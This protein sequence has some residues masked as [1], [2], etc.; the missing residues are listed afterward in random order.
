MNE[1]ITYVRDD[2]FNMSP[3][4]HK[5]IAYVNTPWN[6]EINICAQ[7]FF[8][9]MMGGIKKNFKNTWTP[10]STIIHE[11]AHCVTGQ[12]DEGLRIDGIGD[13]ITVDIK[14][15]PWEAKSGTK[16]YGLRKVT[17]L[18]DLNPEQTLNVADCYGVF[19]DLA[20]KAT[21]EHDIKDVDFRN[22]LP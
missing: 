12:N 18:A 5:T 8:G 10:V 20:V 13:S 3:G 17:L 16:V 9:K 1:M 15:G 2:E 7:K 21:Y 11:V 19:A 14:F 4:N 22:L 6:H